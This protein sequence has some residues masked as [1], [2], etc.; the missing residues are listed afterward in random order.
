MVRWL[1]SL[2]SD[3][4]AN[5]SN[6]IFISFLRRSLLHVTGPRPPC[7]DWKIITRLY[8]IFMNYSPRRRLFFFSASSI[9]DCRSVFCANFTQNQFLT[10]YWKGWCGGEY[11]ERT[12]T[13]PILNWKCNL[14][15]QQLTLKASGERL[16]LKQLW[17]TNGKV[18]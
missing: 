6:R 1:K 11:L 16:L 5:P 18:V 8:W 12:I 2:Q 14:Y 7:T 9:T 15:F 17:A 10:V 4:S 13:V 3:T